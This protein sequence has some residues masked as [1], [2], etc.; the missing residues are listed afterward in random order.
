[1][2]EQ[3]MVAK[4]F[5][6]R[7]DAM[8]KRSEHYQTQFQPGEPI[9]KLLDKFTAFSNEYV[10]L[11][12]QV[13]STISRNSFVVNNGIEKLLQEWNM[14]S[15]ASEQRLIGGLKEELKKASDLAETYCDKWNA[16]LQDGSSNHALETPVV[17]FEKL[18][19]I[20]RSVYAPQIPVISIPLTDYDQ[21]ENWQ[22]LAHELSHHIFWNGFSADQVSSIQQK[23]SKSISTQFLFSS[24]DTD[25]ALLGNPHLPLQA[26]R[27]ALWKNWLEE[28]FADVYGTLL[29]GTSYAISAQD[30]MAEQVN[31]ADDFLLADYQHPCIYLRPLISLYTLDF[32]A[33]QKRGGQAVVESLKKRWLEFSDPA[34]HLEYKN[35]PMD[36]LAKDASKVVEIIL[37]G[38]YWP[39][40]IYPV[41]Q[42]A[43]PIEEK[44]AITSLTPIV[45]QDPLMLNYP[46]LDSVTL[47]KTFEDLKKY[48]M[49]NSNRLFL[50]MGFKRPDE[51]PKLL[52]WLSLTGL[53]LSDTRGYPVHGCTDDHRHLVGFWYQ[54]HTHSQDGSDVLPC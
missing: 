33:G 23:L 22:S 54:R 8:I 51:D 9:R 31:K 5:Q 17:Y 39:V 35:F 4:R 25:T 50:S 13:P 2:A 10:Q 16:I 38:D 49:D 21:S 6:K 34:S 40:P 42:L 12:K 28:I 36:T 37:R 45:D 48:I 20:S 52:A 32:I 44:V 30:R 29:V 41:I 24:A 27:A 47:P 15:R 1:M 19:R 3:L 18:F 14:L 46:P 26:D 11:L 43:S 53:E 7:L